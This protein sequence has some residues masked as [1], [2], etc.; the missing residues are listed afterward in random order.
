MGG[1]NFSIQKCPKSRLSAMN[2]FKV[3]NVCSKIIKFFNIKNINSKKKEIIDQ[4]ISIR[5]TLLIS[6][7]I[8]INQRNH[9]KK[10]LDKIQRKKMQYVDLKEKFEK[11]R[12]E[13]KNNETMDVFLNIYHLT[14]YILSNM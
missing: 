14:I 13:Y 12:V 8:F 9:F 10:K 7:L 3:K 1:Y 6:L 11:I 5:G 2:L 4:N